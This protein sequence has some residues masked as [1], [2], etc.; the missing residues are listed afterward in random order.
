MKSFMSFPLW[1]S[2]SVCLVSYTCCSPRILDIHVMKLSH[3][4]Y[5][6]SLSL[7]FHTW[8]KLRHNLALQVSH[9]LAIVP[10][11]KIQ[12]WFIQLTGNFPLSKIIQSSQSLSFQNTSL[13]GFSVSSILINCGQNL[14]LDFCKN[15]A[16]KLMLWN[17]ILLRFKT[18]FW[19]IAHLPNI[20]ND[21]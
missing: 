3:Q 5:I 4:F 8:Y 16:T 20:I 14:G 1:S 18:N 12:I 13:W 7:E 21:D 9:M 10:F 19:W 2:H 6:L 15:L 17:S 11:K